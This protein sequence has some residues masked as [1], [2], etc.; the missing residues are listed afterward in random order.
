[1]RLPDQRLEHKEEDIRPDAR[2]RIY[3]VGKRNEDRQEL[4]KEWGG[5]KSRHEPVKVEQMQ[6]IWTRRC[7]RGQGEE[8]MTGWEDEQI[9]RFWR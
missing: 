1:M 6:I 2:R 4:N 7:W 5:G 3:A 9:K 8:K